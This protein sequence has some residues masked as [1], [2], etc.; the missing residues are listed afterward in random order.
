MKI[1]IF[2]GG[3]NEAAAAPI[4]GAIVGDTFAEQT[5]SLIGI[6]MTNGGSGYTTPPFIQITDNCNQG[7]GAVARSVVDYDPTSPTY[8]QVTDIYVVS[9]GE[10]YPVIETED[11]GQ[12]TVDH[13]VVVNPGRN[14]KNDDII[15][16]DKG[17]VYDKFLDE[18]GRI[19]NVIPPNPEINNVELV[20]ELPEITIKTTTGTNAVLKAQISPRPEYQG[21]IKQVIDC[22]TPRDGIVGFVNGEPYYGAFHVMTNGVK[23]TGSTHS[24]SDSIIYDTPQDSRSSRAVVASSTSYTTVS[25]PSMT[26]TPPSSTPSTSSMDSTT[27]SPPSPP[28]PPLSLIHI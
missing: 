9:G 10:N 14:Y 26:Y 16:D 25:S 19:L 13:V 24:D 3:G 11:D 2:G 15:E 22:V 7:Y 23:M 21:E 28:S 20:T 17:N 5:G 4:I 8:Q 12:Y 1:N 18:S 27:P 6:K